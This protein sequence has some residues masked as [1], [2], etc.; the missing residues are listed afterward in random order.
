MDQETQ[1]QSQNPIPPTPSTE[2]PKGQI[3]MFLSDFFKIFII[4]LVIIIPVRWFLFQPFVVTG[5]SMRPN[6]H[7]DDY[8]IIDELTYRFKAP[9]RGDV[10]VLRFPNDPSQ[11]F[12]KRIVGLPGDRIM[13]ENGHV[14]IYDEKDPNGVTLDESYLPSNNITYG[15]VNVTLTS[16]EYYV[17][18][19]NRLA[20]S[21]SRIWGPLGRKFIVGR[22]LFRLYSQSEGLH[23]ELVR[24][25]AFSP[26][27]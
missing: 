24:E 15:N 5:D 23:P 16:D 1:T 12:I 19:D 10:I 9:A 4:A 26:T 20:S 14:T 7:N 3:R 13:I 27:P 22:V 17:L 25:P 2:K 8:L 11:F 21:D 6:F 18:G